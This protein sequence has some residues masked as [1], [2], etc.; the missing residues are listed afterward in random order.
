MEAMNAMTDT[1]LGIEQVGPVT[2]AT[3][4]GQSVAIHEGDVH[5]ISEFLLALADDE[6]IGQLVID[7]SATTFFTSSFLAVVTS[8]HSRMIA[9]GARLAL[10]S[11][12]PDCREVVRVTRLDTLWAVYDTRAEA[13]FALSHD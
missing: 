2:V 3:I 6:A 7:L 13:V 5:H 8:V 10:C 1:S 12:K 9:R 11:L 4:G